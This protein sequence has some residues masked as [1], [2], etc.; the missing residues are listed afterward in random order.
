MYRTTDLA[1]LRNGLVCLRGRAGD[2]INV[3]ARK[4]APETI[5]RA[6]E[7][8]PA[9]RG[10]LVFGVPGDEQR[11]E[12]IIAAVEGVETSAQALKQFLLERLE[13]WQVPREFWFVETL[14][15]NSRG[16]VSRADWRQKYLER[17]RRS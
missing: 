13:S 17:T 11:G 4:V 5:E 14:G 9:V 8:H 1:E 16:K 7:S 2:V 6:L 10:C 12:I 3:A 15:A